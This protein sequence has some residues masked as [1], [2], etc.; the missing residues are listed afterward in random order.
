[1]WVLPVTILQCQAL[2]NGLVPDVLGI[3]PVALR[4]ILA[5]LTWPLSASVH[6]GFESNDLTTPLVSDWGE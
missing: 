2:L 1:M 4:A 3:L 6:E 5:D